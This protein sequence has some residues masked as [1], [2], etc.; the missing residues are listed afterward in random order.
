MGE[1]KDII[2]PRLNDFQRGDATLVYTIIFLQWRDGSLDKIYEGNGMMHRSIMEMRSAEESCIVIVMHCC[3]QS[4]G[5][6][7]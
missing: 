5:A 2:W 3:S 6:F 4:G 7:R 1:A